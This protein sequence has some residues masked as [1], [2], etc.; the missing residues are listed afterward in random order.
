MEAQELTKMEIASKW[1]QAYQLWQA[2]RKAEAVELFLVI[3]ENTKLH[4]DEEERL[5]H[6]NSMM[7]V[8]MYY[9]EKGKHK[10]GYLLAKDLMHSD[11]SLTERKNVGLAYSING[12]HYACELL[13]AKKKEETEF[14]CVR[15]IISEIIPYMNE[16]LKNK[17]LAKIPLSWY[18]EGVQCGIAQKYD[19]ALIMY[20]NA[21]AGYRK[22]G[23]VEEEISVLKNIS[24]AKQH[25]CEFDEAKRLYHLASNLARQNGMASKQM[26]ILRDMWYLASITDDMKLMRDCSASIDSLNKV[27]AEVEFDYYLQKGDEAKSKEQYKLA[28]EWYLKGKDLAENNHQYEAATNKHDVYAKLRDLYTTFKRYDDALSYGQMALKE[29]QKQFHPDHD[30]YYLSYTSLADLYRLKGDKEKCFEC[31]DSLFKNVQTIS[32][33][34]KLNALYTTR[35]RCYSSFKY[36]NT[37]LIEYKKADE[38]L[39]TKYSQTDGDRVQ[40]MALMG[41]MEHKLGLYKESEKHY[42]LYAKYIQ[43]LYGEMSLEYINALLWLANAEGFA[44]HLDAGCQ[45]YVAAATALKKQMKKQIPYMSATE[46]EG[47]WKPIASLFYNMTPYALRA[48]C[49]QTSFTK[50]CYDALILSKAFLLDTERSLFDMVKKNGTDEDMR[51]YMRISSIKNRIKKW[52]KNY[53]QFADSILY[54]SEEAERLAIRIVGRFHDISSITDFMDI[55]YEAVKKALKPNEVLLDFTDFVS[56]LEGQ[57]YAV[58]CINKVDEY[59][60][61]KSLFTERQIDSLGITRPDMYYDKDYAPEVFKLLWKPLEKYIPKGSTV[62]YVPSQLLFQISLE[63]LPLA[64]GSLLG[65]HYNFV[66]LSSARELVKAQNSVLSAKPQSAILYGG[67]Q[68]DLQPTAMI[69][70]AKRYVVPDLLVMRS[71]IVRGDSI[72]HELSGSREEVDKIEVILKSHKWQVTSRTGMA[73]TEESFLSMHGKAPQVLQIATHGFYYTPDRAKEVDYLNGYSDAMF[74]SGL[75]LSGGNAAW[76]G[77]S[78]PEGVLGGILTANNITRL[79]LSN[80]EMVVLSAC[81]SGQGKATPEGL[82][83]LQRA[84]K[85]AGVGTIIMALWSVSDIVTAEFMITFYEQ[86]VSADCQWDKRKAFGLTRS[87]MRNKYP[88]P[89]YWAA[90]VMLD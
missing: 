25:L 38:L 58:Y 75:V 67:L 56:Q 51:D 7:M 29:F 2:N 49:F 14:S 10:E 77:R 1:D 44:G 26:D 30:S 19:E 79:D 50:S 54:F 5:R 80:T 31:I 74:L 3:G 52:E 15:E 27:N 46:R 11:L 64:D 8:C 84:F 23:K 82:Y 33:P 87:I 83:G 90:F 86:L 47:F 35:A 21:L 13:K 20:D 57:K 39:A 45:D 37:A 9:T 85:K 4:R 55:D 73:G 40:L 53:K 36:Y 34:R 12:Y 22:L 76:L 72:F 32:E 63:C 81:Q 48:Q 59:P 61:L 66:R 68:Y 88:D 60:L 17:A 18:F 16:Q 24:S 89:F 6:V 69:E 28:E 42:K 41:G 62:Y 43:T 78:L 65:S 71:D 70:E